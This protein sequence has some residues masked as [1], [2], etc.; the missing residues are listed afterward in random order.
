LSIE[1]LSSDNNP[2]LA[3]LQEK[4]ESLTGLFDELEQKVL[5]I[6][7]ASNEATSSAIAQTTNTDTNTNALLITDTLN[8]SG[9]SIF[10]NLALTGSLQ[11]AGLNISQELDSS[12]I[13]HQSSTILSFSGSIFLNGLEIDKSGNVTVNGN[14][15]AEKVHFNGLSLQGKSNAAISGTTTI[16][17]GETEVEVTTTMLKESSKVLLTPATPTPVALKEKSTDGKFT[18]VLPAPSEKDVKVNWV[19]VN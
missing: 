19:I 7:T 1:G 5:G 10:D 6:E 3:S 8:V 11:L 15:T 9:N 2:L 12:T 4:L 17:Q 18:I 13:N 16:R 14:L